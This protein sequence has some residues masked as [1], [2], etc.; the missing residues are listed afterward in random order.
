MRQ[1]ENWRTS[2]FQRAVLFR[3]HAYLGRI[4]H[5]CVIASD[6]F[7]VQPV[8]GESSTCAVDNTQSILHVRLSVQFTRPCLYLHRRHRGARDDDQPARDRNWFPDPS[9]VGGP[10]YYKRSKA[11]YTRVSPS[12]SGDLSSGRT[13]SCR[14]CKFLMLISHSVGQVGEQGRVELWCTGS[15]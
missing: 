14:R 9:D 12:F 11:T 13:A 6:P 2:V 8:R 4:I 1:V 15:S 10:R 7:D 5:P 3:V